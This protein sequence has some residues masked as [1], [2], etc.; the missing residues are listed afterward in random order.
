MTLKVFSGDKFSKKFMTKNIEKKFNK[1]RTDLILQIINEE[2]YVFNNEEF[3]E[4]LSENSI[5]CVKITNSD[6]KLL[7]NYC[8]NYCS[9]QN[10]N[11]IG[12]KTRILF[13]FKKE[14]LEYATNK[15]KNLIEKEYNVDNLK[16]SKEKYNFFKDNFEKNLKNYANSN[17]LEYYEVYNKFSKNKYNFISFI[18]IRGKIKNQSSFMEKYIKCMNSI[19]IEKK[20]VKM[21][22]NFYDG[23][24]EED[25]INLLQKI[26]DN[27]TKFQ[28][29]YNYNEEIFNSSIIGSLELPKFKAIYDE[30]YEISR[31]DSKVFNFNE[32][33]FLKII[34]DKI[35]IEIKA[36][37]RINFK[38]NKIQRFVEIS[39]NLKNINLVDL[40][41]RNY[42]EKCSNVITYFEFKTHLHLL[43]F[44]KYFLLRFENFLKI[45]E[46]AKLKINHFNCRTKKI[47]FESK[48]IYIEKIMFE[49]NLIN[50][51]IEEELFIKSQI[52]ED[53]KNYNFIKSK[54]LTNL[55]NKFCVK[56]ETMNESISSRIVNQYSFKETNNNLYLYQG[57]PD[58]IELD[59]I[60]LN[61]NL[62]VIYNFVDDL[63]KDIGLLTFT[64]K[65]SFEKMKNLKA[66]KNF[67]EF[68][69]FD[70]LNQEILPISKIFYSY[71]NFEKG[72]NISL[73]VI[74]KYLE[75]NYKQYFF[76]S[77]VQFFNTKIIKK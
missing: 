4:I 56:I 31:I 54:N 26:N 46:D 1:I 45:L 41:F 58:N 14:K 73:K 5:K 29:N 71:I 52:I 38:V 57:F 67:T 12:N 15:I 8:N 70:N 42:F 24:V 6:K 20:D 53:E 34:N 36:K 72:N 68:Y 17:N 48:I 64:L 9:Y 60:F 19:L 7:K 77:F 50:Q 66:E 44:R 18:K 33:E 74:A 43:I 27:S 30:F 65:S 32:I 28:Y 35:L 11:L 55:E 63:T 59:Q 21:S 47:S 3:N 22:K 76:Y 61:F 16:I 37:F 49:L 10:E 39:G 62:N 75:E 25:C 69:P 40:F 13:S 23:F 51:N 2:D